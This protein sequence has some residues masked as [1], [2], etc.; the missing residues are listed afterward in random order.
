MMAWHSSKQRK[1]GFLPGL[2]SIFAA[3]IGW[4]VAALLVLPV[5]VASVSRVDFLETDN[6]DIW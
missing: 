5:A 1:P 6:Y 3:H 4:L 2:H